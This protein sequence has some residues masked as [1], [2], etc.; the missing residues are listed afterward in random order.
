MNVRMASRRS[1]LNHLLMGVEDIALKIQVNANMLSVGFGLVFICG[2]TVFAAPLPLFLGS[3]RGQ[4]LLGFWA[5][6]L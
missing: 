2:A 5:E 1:R 3:G 4:Q 6:T